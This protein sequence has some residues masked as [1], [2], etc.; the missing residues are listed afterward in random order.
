MAKNPW[1]LDYASEEIASPTVG[2]AK[3]W[4]LSYNIGTKSATDRIF[5]DG[6]SVALLVPML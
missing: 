6:F 4:E 5:S 1:E 2:D 3:P